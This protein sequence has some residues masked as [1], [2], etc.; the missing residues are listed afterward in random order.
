MHTFIKIKQSDCK[1]CYKCVRHCAVKAIQIKNGH[2][3]IINNRCIQ[4]GK[5]ID[6]CPQK[7]I[8]AVSVLEEVKNLLVTNNNV[9]VS[10][11]PT[12]IIAFPE[13]SPSQFVRSLMKLGFSAVE[14]TSAAAYYV[15]KEYEKIVQ[16]EKLVISSECPALV[17]MVEVYHPELIEFLAPIDSSMLAHAKL[18]KAAYQKNHQ[19]DVKVVYIGPC[20]A[21]KTENERFEGKVDYILNFY[22]VRNWFNEK[23]IYPAIIDN[24]PFNTPKV[25][26]E[27]QN[28]RLYPIQGGLLYRMGI[29]PFD[30]N[31]VKV[32]SF[33][34]CKNFLESI[35]NNQYSLKFVEIMVCED[36]CL[37]APK[38]YQN[39]PQ[40][41][42]MK[43]LTY[44]KST[45]KIPNLFDYSD[46]QVDLSR[47]YK[48]RQ[49]AFRENN[50]EEIQ[51]IL[52]KSGKIGREDELNCGACGYYS[53]RDK[54]NAVLQGMAEYEMCMPYMRERAESRANR[55]IERDP[56]GVCEVDD[57]YRVVQY[58]EAFK[59]IFALPEYTEILNQDIRLYV[60]TDIFNPE[61][62]DKP[63]ILLVSEKLNKEIEVISFDLVEDAMHVVIVTDITQKSKN[64]ER[65]NALKEKTIEKANEVIHKQMRVAQEIASL[66]GETTAETKVILLD[67]MKVFRE[68][69]KE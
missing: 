26:N 35:K 59:N 49:I 29:N 14:E 41:E 21:T 36:G 28:S 45:E 8:K 53:C 1:D 63:P 60:D 4:C 11:S 20:A 13:F 56:N 16:Q 24:T 32:S 50:E 2:A 66:L 38:M 6:V 19:K 43:M 58:N 44:A 57:Q 69:T 68:E 47:E 42:K 65:I 39:S 37:G 7:A 31:F 9:V 25:L 18:L 30:L 46:I 23:G 67:L 12:F 40:L 15:A 27:E 54:A 51:S 34:S 3:Q 17:N 64:R 48:A 61:F 10:I 62:C 33:M 22:D 5:C 55:I 52:K